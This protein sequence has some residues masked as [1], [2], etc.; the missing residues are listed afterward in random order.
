MSK[1]KREEVAP[2]AVIEVKRWSVNRKMEQVRAAV[3]EFVERYN[4]HWRLEKLGF[5]SLQ[6]V[7]Q[8]H[9]LRIAA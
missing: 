9:A 2:G 8:A 1:V 3:G 5:L 6:E 4:A 7:R